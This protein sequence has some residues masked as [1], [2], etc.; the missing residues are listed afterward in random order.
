M[1]HGSSPRTPAN[2]I[3]SCIRIHLQ[4]FLPSSAWVRRGEREDGLR[5]RKGRRRGGSAPVTEHMHSC[6]FGCH[7]GFP[8]RLRAVEHRHP[9]VHASM[10]DRGRG[11]RRQGGR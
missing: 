2:G 9:G 10:L 7:I 3:A 5:F 6:L 4:M 8:Q 11:R 1:P